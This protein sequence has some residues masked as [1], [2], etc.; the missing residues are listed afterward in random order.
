MTC[1]ICGIEHLEGINNVRVCNSMLGAM[2]LRTCSICSAMGA[3]QYELLEVIGKKE[4]RN[5]FT[6]FEDDFYKDYKTGE[7]IPIV[8]KNKPIA[9]QSE[10]INYLKVLISNKIKK[11]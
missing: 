4:I 6:Y 7:V 5:G 9:S 2:S 11:K 8:I 3:E 10:A 1:E